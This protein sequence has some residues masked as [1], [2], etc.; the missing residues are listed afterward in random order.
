MPIAYSGREVMPFSPL[1]KSFLR[2]FFKLAHWLALWRYPA[3]VD[4]EGMSLH[5]LVYWFYTA[6]NPIV[7]AEKGSDLEAYFD[8][9]RQ[10]DPPP[11]PV[12]F[13]KQ[14]EIEL[15][16][17]GDLMCNSLL[18]N[19][20]DCYYQDVAN[21]IFESDISYGNLESS[22]TNADTRQEKKSPKDPPKVNA[23]AKQFSI[24]GGYQGRKYSIL[25]LANNH[26]LDRGLEG[27]ITTRQQ[28]EADGIF[29]V[30]TNRSVEEQK[31]GVILEVGGVRLG[32]VAATY[33]VN[34]QP[35]P[36][37]QTYLVN[38]VRFHQARGETDLSMLLDQVNWCRQ[39]G[40][41][42]VIAGLHWGI[43]W[44]FFP[45]VSQ[46]K[47]A[48]QLA[49]AGVDVILGHHAH[50]IQ[51][52][53]WY[54]TQR[55]PDRWVPILYGLGN[56]VPPFLAPF[57]TL[58]LVARLSLVK[59][60]V[61][62]VQKTFVDSLSLTPLIQLAQKVNEADR[63]WLED[64]QSAVQNHTDGEFAPYLAEAAKYANLVLG[65]RWQKRV[66]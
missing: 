65:N 49:E 21:L 62:G 15:T 23:S 60:R 7:R 18:D 24:V 9:Q 61:K 26:I 54:R 48:H 52:F 5:R 58:S 32:F 56:L 46:I 31:R 42:L 27:L 13:E 37:N 29:Q 50:V 25:Q 47:Q 28:L 22:L 12:G 64:L 20:A 51:P 19:S 1:S 17:V 6:G 53:E 2:I 59:G 34:D 30:G 63:V 40:C 33:S 45:R 36:D 44:E 38:L 55:D 14:A 11:L 16:A 4:V 39:Q 41:D 43:E 35:F 8:Q 66:S 57:N 10:V 3:N